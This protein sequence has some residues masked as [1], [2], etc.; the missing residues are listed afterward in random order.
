[1]LAWVQW[2]GR[3]IQLHGINLSL[4]T[5]R[6]KAS[7]AV[8]RLAPGQAVERISAIMNGGRMKA[9]PATIL[10]ASPSQVK[11]CLSLFAV[12]AQY[13]LPVQCSA[14]I[15]LPLRSILSQPLSP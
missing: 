14:A 7:R 1:M 12:E 8:E 2:S 11:P 10:I 13:L 4:L 9:Q 3:R 5:S 6:V 15:S